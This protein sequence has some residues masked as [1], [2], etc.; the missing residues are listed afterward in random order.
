MIIYTLRWA[1][2]GSSVN[3]GI[4]HVVQVLWNR[5][6]HYRPGFGLD[7]ILQLDKQTLENRKQ[8]NNANS[9]PKR[10]YPTCAKRKAARNHLAH[11]DADRPDDTLFVVN[12]SIFH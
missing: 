6:I 1:F 11:Q 10:H 2:F 5:I 12:V 8:M 3:A 4:E 7:D 9:P